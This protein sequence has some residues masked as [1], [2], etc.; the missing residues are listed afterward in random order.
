[1]ITEPELIVRTEPHVPRLQ[2][3]IDGIDHQTDAMGE[4]RLK[5]KAGH[6]RLE[7]S[8]DDHIVD[9]WETDFENIH[10]RS[11]RQLSLWN[12]RDRRRSS[13]KHAKLDQSNGG[14]YLAVVIIALALAIVVALAR[15]NY[16]SRRESDCPPTNEMVETTQVG[17]N[18]GLRSFW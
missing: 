10:Q 5:L 17:G 2:P 3:R 9:T 13:S 7:L 8:D 4:L 12:C 14:L 16:V 6:H 11:P 18:Q 1:M 15:R